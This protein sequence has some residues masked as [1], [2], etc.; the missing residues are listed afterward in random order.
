MINRTPDYIINQY[1]SW[2]NKIC[3]YRT[4]MALN[5][6]GYMPLVVVA[7]FKVYKK[8]LKGF[9][10]EITSANQIPYQY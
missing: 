6:S 7:I 9:G 2:D 1:V 4:T 8:Q 3:F 10:M 5:N